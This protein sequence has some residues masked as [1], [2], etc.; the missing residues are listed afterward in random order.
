MTVLAVTDDSAL[1]GYLAATLT[2]HAEF[3]TALPSCRRFPPSDILLLD[4]D[5]GAD[6][7]KFR[8]APRIVTVSRE[9]DADLRRPFTD[10]DLFACLFPE[11]RSDLPRLSEDGK[12]LFCFGR[13]I[14]LSGAEA[15]ILS[16]LL[17]AKG[18]EVPREALLSGFPGGERERQDSLS[19]YLSRLRRK[20]GADSPIRIHT[21]QGAGCRLTVTR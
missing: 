5:S 11:N 18:E 21:R 19:V 10:G 1:I 16:L 8:T 14:P 20:L 3:T 13:S 6:T 4:I 7:A 12:Y 9:K 15:R 2:G 17:A